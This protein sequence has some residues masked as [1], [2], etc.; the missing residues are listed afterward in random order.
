MRIFSF[1]SDL[2]YVVIYIYI[3]VHDY[4]Y[5]HIYISL[6]SQEKDR[7]QCTHKWIQFNSHSVILFCFRIHLCFSRQ[8]VEADLTL[9]IA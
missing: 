7:K 1:V 4:R 8:M 3:Y 2:P 6:T 5:M 9:N